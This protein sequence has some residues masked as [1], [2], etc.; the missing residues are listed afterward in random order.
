MVQALVAWG[1]AALWAGVLFLL[2]E[3]QWDSRPVLFPI[4][5]KIVHLVLYAVLGALLGWGREWSGRRVGH[6][7]L[8][9][10]G[11]AYGFLDEW[12]QSFVPGRHPSAGDLLADA[13]GVTGGYLATARA[14]STLFPRGAPPCQGGRL[15]S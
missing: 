8:I 13:V 15:R 3:A 11:T 2:S 14:L 6:G 1:P 12:H 5:D 9:L 10:I 7:L 4:D